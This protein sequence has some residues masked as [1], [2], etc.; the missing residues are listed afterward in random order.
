MPSVSD[1]SVLDTVGTLSPLQ[2][3]QVEA[4]IAGTRRDGSIPINTPSGLWAATVAA[5]YSALTA[6]QCLGIINA[7]GAAVT[8]SQASQ[9]PATITFDADQLVIPASPWTTGA[10]PTKIST[11]RVSYYQWNKA[12]LAPL[13]TPNCI[14]I[15]PGVTHVKITLTG[16][17]LTD[18]AAAATVSQ[19]AFA[20]RTLFRSTRST[21]FGSEFLATTWGSA[22]VWSPIN[23]VWNIDLW[24]SIADLGISA[25]DAARGGTAKFWFGR[26]VS[27][28]RDLFSDNVGLYS[29][30]I[31]PIVG[32]PL[33][34]N[35][36]K[37]QLTTKINDAIT[38]RAPYT[39]A[40][41]RFSSKNHGTPAY[42]LSSTRFDVPGICD[43]SGTSLWNSTHAEF[44]GI[45]LVGPQHVLMCRHY[46]ATA[47]STVRFVDSSGT[48]HSRTLVT[49]NLFTNPTDMPYIDLATGMLDSP[50]PANVPWYKTLSQT[51]GFADKIVMK[52]KGIP[53]VMQFTGQD[54]MSIDEIQ[55]FSTTGLDSAAYCLDAT[56]NGGLASWYINY[57]TS[58]DSG[59]PLWLLMPDGELV[60]VGCFSA[61]G[62]G[63]V[64]F[65]GFSCL[66]H[67]RVFAA[68]NT[69]LATHSTPGALVPYDFSA[70]PTLTGYGYA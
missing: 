40:K 14:T 12:A 33:P 1:L 24:L 15:P 62:G 67:P 37:A 63:T 3:V 19:M 68:A 58:T 47:G 55:Y 16:K 34:S 41:A 36:L 66:A 8:T 7:A 22:D 54:W 26:D 70:Y 11:E 9:I 42:T 65:K 46:V 2:Q 39:N 20:I 10:A 44:R 50:L 18:W 6:Q 28:A 5:G 25:M 69:S 53:V 56:E 13:V 35:T 4:Y 38:A 27:H 52:G 30:S 31:T 51:G 43:F 23:T 17:A 21:T 64:K 57:S 45:T 59:S 61:F 49:T 32:L 48:L 29:I 60:L